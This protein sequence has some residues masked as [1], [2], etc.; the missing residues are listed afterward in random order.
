MDVKPQDWVLLARPLEATDLG[1]QSELGLGRPPGLRVLSLRLAGGALL[2]VFGGGLL[3]G[4]RRI[5]VE[6]W[7]L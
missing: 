3:H 6:R 4:L 1:L 5:L 2:V 7:A